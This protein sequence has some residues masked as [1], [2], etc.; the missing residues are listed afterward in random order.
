MRRKLCYR[1][2]TRFKLGKSCKTQTHLIETRPSTIFTENGLNDER[3]R[4]RIRAVHPAPLHSGVDG[5]HDMRSVDKPFDLQSRPISW[6]SNF[7][8][9]RSLPT[10]L[11]K[12][13]KRSRRSQEYPQSQPIPN[14]PYA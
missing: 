13:A 12:H 4:V 5:G 10:L 6:L 3:A 8:V 9:L 7:S 14:A 2:S 1:E 11:T